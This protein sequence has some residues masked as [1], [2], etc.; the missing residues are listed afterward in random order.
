MGHGGGLL[1]DSM[2]SGFRLECCFSAGPGS[3]T[4]L[5][6]SEYRISQAFLHLGWFDLCGVDNPSLTCGGGLGALSVSLSVSMKPLATRLMVSMMELVELTEAPPGVLEGAGRCMLAMSDSVGIMAGAG[7]GLG[8]TEAVGVVMT[9]VVTEAML[10][11]GDDTWN[12]CCW[13]S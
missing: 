1:P 3:G 12:W 4:F 13:P 8:D 9:D 10:V 11:R 2:G 6:S 5:S 7:V